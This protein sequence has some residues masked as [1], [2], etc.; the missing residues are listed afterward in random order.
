MCDGNKS[1]EGEKRVMDREDKFYIEII[2]WQL[3]FM[4]P[5]SHLSVLQQIKKKLIYKPD[6]PSVPI[7]KIFFNAFI[8][9]GRLSDIE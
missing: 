5:R 2:F 6:F 1:K 8:I 4:P 9:Q 3:I 7:I